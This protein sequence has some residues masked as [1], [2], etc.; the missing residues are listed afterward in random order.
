[1]LEFGFSTLKAHMGKR[2]S[3]IKGLLRG[4]EPTPTYTVLP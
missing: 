4:G 2:F 1:M 3:D